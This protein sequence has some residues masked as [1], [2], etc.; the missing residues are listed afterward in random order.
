MRETAM[1]SAESNGKS[2]VSLVEGLKKANYAD[3]AILEFVA[4]EHP[5][6]SGIIN[7]LKDAGYSNE[8]I[9][10]LL[11]SEPVPTPVQQP[12]NGKQMISEQELTIRVTD[13]LMEIGMPAHLSGYRYTRSAIVLAVKDSEIM[14]AVTKILYPKVANQHASTSNCVE[15]AIRHA[16]EVGWDRGDVDVLSEY[17]GNTI[18]HKRG[19][20]TNSE[21]IAA[22]ADKLRLQYSIKE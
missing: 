21:F 19:K 14:K 1:Y 12:E 2:V 17:F 15:R 7:Q 22:I 4:S 18:H 3:S 13:I 10:N 6:K 20:P 8:A 5:E 16:I 9:L 11:I